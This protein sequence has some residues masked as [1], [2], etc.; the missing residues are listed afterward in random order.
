MESPFKFLEAYGK[1]DRHL[2]FG[3]DQEIEELYSL[4]RKSNLVVV[5]GLSGVG[6]TSLIRCG[7]VNEFDESE[8]VIREIRRRQHIVESLKENLAQFLKLPGDPGEYSPAELV[9]KTFNKFLR[10][11]FLF[12]DQFEEL[13][14]L[15]DPDEKREFMQALAA[16]RELDIPCTITLILRQE[17]LGHLSDLKR[18]VPFLFDYTL[19]VRQMD[20]HT[21]EEVVHNMFQ[22]LRATPPGVPFDFELEMPRAIVDIVANKRFFVEL[23][24]LQV[25]LDKS[26]KTC[27]EWD[28]SRVFFS[29]T[30]LEDPR[31]R[32]IETVLNDLLHEQ[33]AKAVIAVGEESE[34]KVLGFLKIF[35]TENDTKQPVS[36]SRIWEK[37]RDQELEDQQIEKCLEI[38][39]KALLLR[40]LEGN[41]YELT[42]DSLASQIALKRPSAR[43]IQPAITGNP[44]K[45]LAAFTE[46][47]E[48]IRRFFGR[49]GAIDKVLNI[50]EKYPLAVIS[51]ASG[52]GKSSLVKAGVYP[53]LRSMGFQLF[54]ILRPGEFPLQPLVKAMENMQSKLPAKN[55]LALLVDQYEE[56]ITRSR[57][58][59]EVGEFIKRLALLIEQPRSLLPGLHEDQQ[60]KVIITVRSDFEPQFKNGPL[61][62]YWDAGRFVVPFMTSRELEMVIEGPADLAA[63]YFEPP[64]LIKNIAE[65][66]SGRPSAL[67][68]LSFALSEMFEASLP[69][70]VITQDIYNR[71]GVFGALQSSANALY[72]SLHDEAFRGVMRQVM[73]R[74]VSLE[75][76][77]I[78]SRRVS[79]EEL[80]Y[81]SAEEN[82]RVDEVLMLLTKDRL[83]VRGRGEEGQPYVEPAHD[84]LLRGWTRLWEWIKDFGKENILFRERLH[85]AVAEWQEQKK[86][87]DALWREES[88]IIQLRL[89][90]EDPEPWLNAAER[91]FATSSVEM[92]EKQTRQQKE[93][94]EEKQNLIRNTRTIQEKSRRRKLIAVISFAASML[95]FFVALAAFKNQSLAKRN[96]EKALANL[97]EA[98]KRKAEAQISNKKAEAAR[99]QA[100]KAAALA[101][102]NAVAA[103]RNK[104]LAEQNLARAREEERKTRAALLLVEEEKNA[105]EEQRLEASRNYAL[106]QSRAEQLAITR[107]SLSLAYQRAQSTA[108]SLALAQ[109]TI[110]SLL[111]ITQ[112]E[113]I[114]LNDSL[115]VVQEKVS[116]LE[117]LAPYEEIDP[118]FFQKEISRNF[119]YR[120]LWPPIKTFQA[121]DVGAYYKGVFVKITSLDKLGVEFSVIENPTGDLE[122]I[123]E[124]VQISTT[125]ADSLIRISMP[126]KENIYF[127]MCRPVSTRIANL[128]QLSESIR[129]LRSEK[130]WAD[131]YLVVTEVVAPELLT[132][133]VSSSPNALIELKATGGLDFC[134]P[135]L[136]WSVFEEKNISFKVISGPQITPLIKTMGL[137]K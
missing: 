129:K 48:D 29:R 109:I 59:E 36:L 23:P 93:K 76:S 18:E 46:S 86:A 40:P 3:R 52:T 124:G 69:R 81:T 39:S 114:T 106:A 42:H 13:F 74:M 96:E 33:I 131:D 45:G 73:L 62:K 57:E 92:V 107:D 122:Y 113:V 127:S 31:L 89:A 51:G 111:K 64:S 35:V 82:A 5:Y 136:Q 134:S 20:R 110:D 71:I 98:E 7:L 26:F 60:V 15:G 6:K 65:E 115:G 44:Y 104:L 75:G 49:R 41:Q 68:L 30:L 126:K 50:L 54:E 53:E 12:F 97:Q 55:G 83:V 56:L 120:A 121:G 133:I 58:E 8:V 99:K 84:A 79:V 137:R 128:N 77:E 78:A 87:E 4:I 67:P 63:C 66:V 25:Y 72:D 91:E 34:A 22:S 100:E 24:Y 16:I 108:D 132:V 88:Q 101:M 47:E 123:S 37:A 117:I 43:R 70:R 118:N 2:F 116:T 21:T 32:D 11:I 9:Q 19:Q 103:E 119:G 14:I 27:L 61:E 28:S 85:A 102:D 80:R 105:T 112:K 1:N 38:F 94:E 10:P 125:A 17:Y 130:N 135:S 90:L 95:F